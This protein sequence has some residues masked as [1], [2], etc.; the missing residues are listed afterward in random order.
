MTNSNKALAWLFFAVFLLLILS[1]GKASAQYYNPGFMLGQQIGSA[2]GNAIQQRSIYGRNKLRKQIN[3]WGKCANGS[4]SLE[5]GAVAIYGRNGY[6]CSPTV[7]DGL[8]SKL[9]SINES[10]EE[11]TDVNILEN[12]NYIV[13]YD[14]GNNW[15]GALPS[16]LKS[17]LNA[18]PSSLALKS[19]SF[20]ESGTYA[21]T[22]ANGFISNNADYQALYDDNKDGHGELLSVN[23]CG[24]GAVFCYS[25]GA[26]FCGSVPS[27]VVSA[28]KN[29]SG[30]A[31]F[32]KFNKH[33]DFLI[34]S[35]QGAYQYHIDDANSGSNA[36]TT[37]YDYAKE[38]WNTAKERAYAKWEGSEDVKK[39][40]NAETMLYDVH[41]R[42]YSLADSS[43]IAQTVV[44]KDSGDYQSPG[45]VFSIIP[46]NGSLFFGLLSEISD[47][48]LQLKPV[49]IL[50]SNGE[51]LT[52]KAMLNFTAIFCFTLSTN[53]IH[54]R[55]D[56]RSL[57]GDLS[58]IKYLVGQLSYYNIKTLIIDD[59]HVIDFSGIDTKSQFCYDFCKVAEGCGQSNILPN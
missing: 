55:S 8:K 50:L 20:N 17:I 14:G 26:R 25:D 31:R 5:H 29:F 46:G 43:I 34:C 1:A 11:I 30:T 38:R 33:G 22:T 45:M 51:T 21:I 37:Y 32:V 6:F 24:D 3:K 18:L 41:C 48:T 10:S 4:L 49:K 13:V 44:M 52:L 9:R 39:A 16:D 15:S 2:I 40:F 57:N 19:V 27:N 58:S 28:A 59:Q 53:L 23:I 42:G 7:P 36:A 12:G 56:K 35:K 54:F 47:T